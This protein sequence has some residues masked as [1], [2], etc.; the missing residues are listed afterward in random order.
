MFGIFLKRRR[1]TRGTVA[2]A[3]R[4]TTVFCKL[5]DA[6]PNYINKFVRNVVAHGFAA[7]A[8]GNQT[9]DTK[10]NL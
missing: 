3:A 5:F 8:A 7:A 1:P 10:Y 6:R 4:K 2:Q 9:I